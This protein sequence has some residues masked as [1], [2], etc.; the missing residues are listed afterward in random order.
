MMRNLGKL[1]LTLCLLTVGG[2][3]VTNAQIESLARVQVNVPFAFSVGNTKLP[4]GKY[5]ISTLDDSN[6]ILEL[7]SD[8]G[9]TSVLFDTQDVEARGDQIPSK[10]EVVFD[11][12]GD[13]YFLTQV[14]VAGEAS[15]S[16]LPKSRMEK[17]L[18]DGGS[19]S[20]RHSIAGFLKHMKR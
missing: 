3:V 8:N 12:F 19:H 9:R 2:G 10:T 14:W 17:R 15:G 16:E 18:E 5:Q 6:K 4:A 13:Q 20:E 1:L 11:R 7:R